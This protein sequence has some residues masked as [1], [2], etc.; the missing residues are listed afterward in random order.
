MKN[1]TSIMKPADYSVLEIP[2]HQF[3]SRFTDEFDDFV[4]SHKFFEIVFINYGNIKHSINKTIYEM[5]VGDAFM[6]APGI[7]HAFIRK[8][9]CGHRDV[10][11]APPLFKEI[12]D[13]IHKGLYEQLN[14]AGF[15]KFS[16]SATQ[17][18]SFENAY[19]AINDTDDIEQQHAC[20]KLLSTQLVGNLYTNTQVSTTMSTFK[21]KCTTIINEHYKEKEILDL[22][23]SEL[24]Y[25]QGHLCKK[26]KASFG[27]TPTEYVN[28]KRISSAASTFALSNYSV[29]E[30]CYSVGF[31]S[32]PHFIKLFKEHYGTTP[33]KYKKT[34]KMT[35]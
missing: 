9:E 12:C 8:E 2:N 5:S 3:V 28:K 26:F 7:Q 22:L 1:R 6:V 35:L 11:I 23:R 19:S 34:H 32:V 21:S 10:M 15:V 18:E 33:A 31:D 14:K 17:M 24:G 29:E 25:T 20:E 13:Y 4:H 27:V 16:M 30:C